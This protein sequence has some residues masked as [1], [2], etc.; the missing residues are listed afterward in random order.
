MFSFSGKVPKPMQMC[1][2]THVYDEDL[3]RFP[4]RSDGDVCQLV[5]SALEVADGPVVEARLQA[6][7]VPREVPALQVAELPFMTADVR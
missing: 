4:L 1:D 5:E 6:A 3:E 7:I 2:K